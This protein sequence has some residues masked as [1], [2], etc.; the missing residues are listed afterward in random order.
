MTKTTTDQAAQVA[1]MFSDSDL[2]EV[3]PQNTSEI[4]ETIVVQDE[5]GPEYVGNKR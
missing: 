5:L 2:P 3:T 1:Q 4:K